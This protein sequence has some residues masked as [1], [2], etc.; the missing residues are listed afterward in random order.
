[1]AS[2][3]GIE[4]GPDSFLFA[5][6]RSSRSSGAEVFA[7]RR[8]DA[9]EWPEDERE[10][11]D[12]VQTIRHAHRFP[13]H[14]AV[15]VWNTSDAVDSS[16]HHDLLGSLA[17]SGFHVVSVLTP[18]QALTRVAAAVPRGTPADAIAWLALNTWGASI[19][20]VRDGALLFSRTFS[21]TYRSDHPTAKAQLL[22]RYLLIA[23]L[24][25]ELAHGFKAVRDAH[26]ATVSLAITCGNLPELR[27]LTLPLIEELDVEVETL[28]STDGLA[29]RSARLPEF[30][31]LAPALRLAT[32][33]AAS[34]RAATGRQP[35]WL[36]LSRAAAAAAVIAA[37]AWAGYSYWQASQPS[38]VL[39]GGL[40]Q[41][42]VLQSRAP[43][44][45][46]STPSAASTSTPHP[47]ATRGS[48]EPNRASTAERA[49][50]SRAVP[51]QLPRVASDT[52]T[53]APPKTSEPVAPLNE[54]LPRVDT[55]LIDQDRRL[56]ILD[57]AVVGVGDAVGSRTVL[58]IAREAILLREPSGRIV[59]VRPRIGM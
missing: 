58:A 55:V 49:I 28:D 8:Y 29:A 56:A 15:V 2:A 51:A 3:T 18:P 6:V 31:E 12:A 53:A 48:D 27:S 5:G 39:Q 13:R 10:L 24:A 40:P 42:T 7:A 9:A 52:R 54:P 41:P 23:H 17:A 36:Y 20:I 1:M 44:A 34:S 46:I 38:P 26:G 32:A 33:A 16:P 11:S 19:A 47:V 37:V 35:P 43:A 4:I 22:Q 50:P 57:G 14:A 45:A 21:W 25:P 30:A 59:R